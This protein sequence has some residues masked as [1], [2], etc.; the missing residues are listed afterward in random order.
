MLSRYIEGRIFTYSTLVML[1]SRKI[2]KGK[3]VVTDFRYLNVR[4]A[5]NNLAYPLLKD[6]FSVLGSSKCDVLSVLDLMH[7]FHSLRLSENSK[8]YCST[9]PYFGSTSYL[10]QRMPMGLNISPPYGNPTSMLSSI[11]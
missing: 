7:A 8:K 2:T 4:I 11:V 6:T 9:L 10:Y 3:R 1:I 5:K